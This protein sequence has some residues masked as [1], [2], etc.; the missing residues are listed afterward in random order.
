MLTEE[1][2]TELRT[3]CAQTLVHVGADATVEAHWLPVMER[4]E[5]RALGYPF[6][7]ALDAFLDISKAIE[8]RDALTAAIQASDGC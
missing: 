3:T 6:G 1:P 8:L 2:L 7:I 4:I 5:V